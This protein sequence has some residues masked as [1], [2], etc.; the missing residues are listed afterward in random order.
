MGRWVGWLVLDSHEILARLAWNLGTIIGCTRGVGR[1]QFLTRCH[2]LLD[3][4]R[5]YVSRKMKHVLRWS[6]VQI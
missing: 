4:Y 2:H 3:Y 5:L 1:L 6:N